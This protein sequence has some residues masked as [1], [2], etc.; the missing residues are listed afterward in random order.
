MNDGP[1]AVSPLLAEGPRQP[2]P[3]LRPAVSEQRVLLL[4]RVEPQMVDLVAGNIRRWENGPPVSLPLVSGPVDLAAFRRLQFQILRDP[5]QTSVD[6]ILASL[7][8][9]GICTVDVIA[10]V[11]GR[12]SISSGNATVEGP[13]GGSPAIV[14]G[15][16][17]REDKL[18]IDARNAE[19]TET[20]ELVSAAV[21][22]PGTFTLGGPSTNVTGMHG[23]RRMS[24]VHI[25]V[26]RTPEPVD[27]VRRTLRR[28]RSLVRSA[29]TGIGQ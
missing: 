16:E 8:L 3:S 11:G 5:R 17:V 6:T 25:D 27:D 1:S 15:F 9:G 4:D 29:R 21:G 18:H 10:R 19:T 22:S 26:T 14:I 23:R 20:I 24:P 28:L 13:I 7:A 2:V 12:I